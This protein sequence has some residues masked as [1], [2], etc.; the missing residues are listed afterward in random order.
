MRKARAEIPAFGDLPQLPPHF[1]SAIYL[2][3]HCHSEDAIDE[4]IINTS[5]IITETGGSEDNC[6]CATTAAELNTLKTFRHAAPELVN[7]KIDEHR[8]EHPLL[9]K[10][11]TD[12][13]APDSKLETIMQMYR[14]GL[15]AEALEYV[16]FG[17]IGNNHLHVNIIPKNMKEYTAGKELY[18]TWAKKI[19]DLGGSISAEHG[20]GKI[21]TPLL[22]LMYG[23][24]GI[25]QM[26]KTKSVFD[27]KGILNPGTLFPL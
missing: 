6:W 4:N 9:T 19:I 3:Y 17:H 1:H 23:K 21:K 7:L 25:T 15:H 5:G 13:S 10:L 8:K 16:I 18:L 2:E 22:E 20:I 24:D 27:P 14:E 12:M 26:K 11:G